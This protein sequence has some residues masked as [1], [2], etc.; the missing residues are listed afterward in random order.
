M[1]AEQLRA[2]LKFHL[3][4]GV[5]AVRLRA[6]LQAFGDV[7]SAARAG[8]EAWLR[9]EGIACAACHKGSPEKK[10]LSARKNTF[11][12]VGGKLDFTS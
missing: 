3:A 5:G 8:R 7:Q 2:Y 6:I 4:D 12:I 11:F 9:V 10:P 1:P